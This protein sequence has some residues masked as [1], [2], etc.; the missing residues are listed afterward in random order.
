MH[1][2]WIVR[3]ERELTW[4][5]E[6]ATKVL[7]ELRNANRPDRL[8]L[9]LYVTNSDINAQNKIQNAAHVVVINEGGSLT[10][11]VTNDINYEKVTLLTPNRKRRDYLH[12][13]KSESVREDYNLATEFPHLACRVR[14]GRPHWDRLFGYWMH[15]YPE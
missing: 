5:A 10:H 7:S 9:E 4:L 14:K 12:S 8:Q 11:V 3:H 1:L 15:L 2:L 13:G 6:L